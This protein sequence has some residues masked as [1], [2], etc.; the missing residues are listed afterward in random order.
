MDPLFSTRALEVL[1][2]GLEAF[3]LRG[4]VIE[5]NIANAATPG[6]RARTVRFEEDLRRA[7]AQGDPPVRPEPRP[8]H[9][10]VGGAPLEEIQPKVV[11][12]AKAAPSGKANNVL[13]ERERTELAR[14]RLRFEAAAKMVAEHYRLLETAIRGASRQPPSPSDG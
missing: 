2:L 4:R 12:A 13:V 8:G 9:I 10:P 3:A 1:K 11:D 14:N 5:R 7:L 6:Y